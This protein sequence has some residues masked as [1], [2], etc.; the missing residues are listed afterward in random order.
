MPVFKVKLR[1]VID[2]TVDIEANTAKEARMLVAAEPEN[3]FSDCD[4]FTT[5]TDVVT[6]KSVKPA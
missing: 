2:A 5:E 6:V 1:R 3:V 4:A